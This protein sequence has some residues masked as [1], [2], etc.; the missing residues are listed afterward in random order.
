MAETIPLIPLEPNDP[1]PPGARAR[2]WQ[3]EQ[4]FH[5]YAAICTMAHPSGSCG[6]NIDKIRHEVIVAGGGKRTPTS[7]RKSVRR[8]EEMDMIGRRPHTERG[9]R[10]GDFYTLKPEKDWT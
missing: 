3:F 7:V 4:D 5:V 1:V 10:I 8:L 6:T 2:H 9:Q